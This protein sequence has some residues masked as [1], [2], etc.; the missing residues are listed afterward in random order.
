MSESEDLS[1]YKPYVSLPSWVNKQLSAEDLARYK[2]LIAPRIIIDKKPPNP[3]YFRNVMPIDQDVAP[4]EG[5]TPDGIVQLKTMPKIPLNVAPPQESENISVDLPTIYQEPIVDKKPPQA[6]YKY[7]VMPIDQGVAP[8]YQM[9]IDTGVGEMTIS[10]QGVAPVDQMP[11]V[12]ILKKA[13]KPIVGK[14]APP[15]EGVYGTFIPAPQ[16]GMA[17][18]NILKKIPIRPKPGG[19]KDAYGCVIG[20]GYSWCATL[21]KCIRSWETPCPKAAYMPTPKLI[22]YHKCVYSKYYSFY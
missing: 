7:N 20:A 14:I 9:P 5:V 10:D 4:Q 22:S 11:G 3:L 17:G 18:P 2:K 8:D 6:L 21:N 1:V 13:P 15:Q 16:E 19:Q 12:A